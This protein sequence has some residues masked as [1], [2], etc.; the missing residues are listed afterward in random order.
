MIVSA[1]VV[2]IMVP[3]TYP[4]EEVEPQPISLILD[5]PRFIAP[6]ELGHFSITHRHDG[7][8]ALDLRAPI[9]TEVIASDAGEV[10]YAGTMN[11]YGKVVFIGHAGG[12]Q[13]RYAHLQDIAVSEGER[14]HQGQRLGSVGMTGRTT[15]PHLHFEILT[16]G[17]RTSHDLAARSFAERLDA[18]TIIAW[19]NLENWSWSGRR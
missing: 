4:G 1:F 17:S 18:E 16:G 19:L 11:G 10:V 8:R 14:V 3:M 9:G 5:E 6:M 13:T 7:H 12:I 15:G 2:S